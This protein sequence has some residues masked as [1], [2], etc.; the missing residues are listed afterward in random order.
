[1][2]VRRRRAQGDLGG[3]TDAGSL[4]RSRQLR[5]GELRRVRG[6]AAGAGRA[7]E[8]G[9]ESKARKGA[10]VGAGRIVGVGDPAEAVEYRVVGVEAA[11]HRGDPRRLDLWRQREEVGAE[12]SEVAVVEGRGA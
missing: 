8:A 9:V 5:G 6:E 1:F 11:G 10:D 2:R 3:Q 7:A 12:A 4:Q